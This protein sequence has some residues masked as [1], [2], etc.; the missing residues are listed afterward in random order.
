MRTL[1]A[2]ALLLEYPTE[3]LLAATDEIVGVIA[4]DG[5]LP[6]MHVEALRAMACAREKGGLSSAQADYVALFD[7]LPGASLYLFQHLYGA[8]RDRGPALLALVDMYRE[9]GLE[10]ATSETADY[11]PLFLEFASVL[12]DKDARALIGGTAHVFEILRE[13]L[14]AWRSAY[15]A[16]FGALVALADRAPDKAELERLAAQRVRGPEEF[17]VLD[18]EW[19]DRPVEFKEG[20]A[21]ET[22]GSVGQERKLQ[23]GAQ[24]SP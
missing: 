13:R 12:P 8:S 5:A 19:E 3:E 18:E 17:G 2:L 22:C 24:C 21:M 15:A 10:L 4:A 20:A 16:V 14:T 6:A 1:K 9:R 23:G 7:M 11:I